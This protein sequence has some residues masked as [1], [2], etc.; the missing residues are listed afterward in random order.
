M[1]LSWIWV[2]Y[3][4]SQSLS[5]PANGFLF[6]QHSYTSRES[7]FPNLWRNMTPLT[8]RI[9]A[10][11]HWHGSGAFF[12]TVARPQAIALSEMGVTMAQQHRPGRRPRTWSDDNHWL[13]AMM[14]VGYQEPWVS[15]LIMGFISGEP[16][17][18]LGLSLEI[19]RLIGWSMV[20]FHHVSRAI[21]LDQ[22]WW[23]FARHG[24]PIRSACLA[25][26]VSA[27]NVQRRCCRISLKVINFKN[28]EN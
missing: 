8:S 22:R 28:R 9:S 14:A 17:G 11:S 6:A 16:W 4:D 27:L 12:P 1:K 7:R 20:R 10:P 18:N 24:T 2:C 3:L 15:W 21:D 25:L 26:Q 19:H 5:V 13:T 23:D